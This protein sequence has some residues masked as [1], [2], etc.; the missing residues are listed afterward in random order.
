M[1]DA[2][3]RASVLNALQELRTNFTINWT[4]NLEIFVGISLFMSAINYFEIDLCWNCKWKVNIIADAMVRDR[5]YATCTSLR[6]VFDNDTTEENYKAVFF[7]KDL[8]IYPSM[9]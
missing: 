3:N 8:N 1:T 7:T 9:R 4:K 6:V 2:S 5:F